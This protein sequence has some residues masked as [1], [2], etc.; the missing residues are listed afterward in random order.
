MEIKLNQKQIAW[1]PNRYKKIGIGIIILTI[2]SS[3]VFRFL[4]VEFFRTQKHLLGIIL[5]NSFILG[6]FIIAWSKEKIEDEMTIY[7]RL[8]AIT[9]SFTFAV[10]MVIM[11]PVFDTIFQDPLENYSGQEIIIMMLI[12]FLSSYNMMKIRS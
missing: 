8:S 10:I 7:M 4:D 11:K 6:L 9:L 12:I 3:I 5:L 2:I 1:F